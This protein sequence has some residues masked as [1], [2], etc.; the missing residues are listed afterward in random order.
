MTIRI[1][2]G[3]LVGRIQKRNVQYLH[4]SPDVGG[5]DID[6]IVDGTLMST[7]EALITDSAVIRS[8]K[9]H[10]TKAQ[11]QALAKGITLPAFISATTRPPQSAEELAADL[12]VE[13]LSD[14][15]VAALAAK[16]SDRI[17]AITGE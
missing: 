11:V 17:K 7:I 10:K 1:E 4:G 16:L 6:V 5:Y 15:A 2:N 8:R 12:N 9:I 13:E 3:K 14:A